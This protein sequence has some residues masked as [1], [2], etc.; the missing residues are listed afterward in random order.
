MKIK[1]LLP[2]LALVILSSCKKVKDPEF[3][4]IDHFHVKSLGLQQTTIGFN[5]TYFNPNNFG[6]TVKETAADIYMDSVYLGKFIQDSSVAVNKNSE[7]SIPLSGAV[8]MKTALQMNFQNIGNRDILV[9]ADGNVRVG[10]AGIF[11]TKPIHY[12]GKHKLSE[13]K[14]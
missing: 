5:V 11:V 9:K 4:R 7:F 12:Q 1:S 8:A 2:F 6:V 3:R 14:F 10:K 13:V